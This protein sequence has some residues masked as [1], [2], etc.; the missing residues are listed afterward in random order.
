MNEVT[1]ST[2]ATSAATA[3]YAATRRSSLPTGWWGMAL[4]IATEATLFGA[5]IS[6]YFYLR[7]N[8]VQWPP[9]GVEPPAVALPL[10]LTAALVATTAPLLLAVRAA[11]SGRARRAA[12]LLGAA[13]AIQAGYI[14][15]Q[16]VLFQSDLGK[17]SPEDSA[18]GSIYF[19]MLAL[20]HAHVVVGMGLELWLVSRLL[21]GL[22]N[23]RV[24]AVRAIALYWYF[25]N[26]VTIPVVLTQLSPSL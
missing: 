7:F 6:T 4:L 11:R 25:V 18:Y 3:A 2:E 9:A 19:T 24:V 13:L 14:A 16:V 1:R 21:A 8:A 12:E 10:V 26:A 23:Y 15:V 17:F 5:V 22:T 20:D